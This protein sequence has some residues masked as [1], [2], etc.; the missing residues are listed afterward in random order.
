MNRTSPWL[1]ARSWDDLTEATIDFLEGRLDKSPSHYS[2]PAE[3]TSGL[4]GS[5]AGMN[6]AGF[7]TMSSQPGLMEE[8][9]GNFQRAYVDGACSEETA[10]T[11]ESGLLLTG[12]V[13]ITLTPEDDSSSTIVVTISDG[14]PCTF[15]GRSFPDDLDYYRNG[16]PGLDAALDAMWRVQIFDPVWGRND[17]LWAEVNRALSG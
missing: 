3:E 4:V 12:L 13:V 15:V 9:A 6:R 1:A 14:E 8:H 10:L 5:L 17:V 7:L 16:D 11:L 2:P